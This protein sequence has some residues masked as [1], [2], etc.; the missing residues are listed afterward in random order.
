MKARQQ[1]LGTYSVKIAIALLILF[2]G[3]FL[4]LR[5]DVSRNR[6]YSLTPQTRQSL[7]S[8]QDRVVVK[9]FASQDLSPQLSN[10]NRSLRDMLTEFARLSRGKLQFE[11]VRAKSNEDLIEQAKQYS[12]Q[13]YTVVT[14]ENDQQV[15]KLVVLG[16]SF[17]SGGKTSATYLR[18]GMETMLEYQILKHLNQ[19]NTA[20]LPALSVFA[21]SLGLMFQYGN[22]PDE[23]A[24]FFLELMQNYNIVRTDL[25]KPPEFTP[26]MLC[27]G[28]IDSLKTEQLYNLDQYLMRGGMVVMCQDR[29]AVFNTPQGTGVIEIKSALYPL[30]EHYGIH[31]KPNIVLDRECEIRQGS[32]LGS[33]VPYPFFPLIRPNPRYPYTMGFESIYLYFASEVTAMAGSKLKY[34]PVLQTSARSNALDGPRYD[35]ELAINQGLDP[36]FLNLPPKTVAAEFSGKITSYYNA[37]PGDSNYRASNDKARFIVFGD[38]E[39]PIDFGAGTFIVLNAVDQLLGR[40]GMQRLRSPREN[41]SFLGVDVLIQKRKLAPSDPERE[42]SHLALAFKLTAIL[43]PSLL[44]ALAGII[45]LVRKNARE[46]S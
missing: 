29:V 24:T 5:L 3:G 12:I 13:P 25:L 31:I 27:L 1:I 32:G 42:T 45:S 30:L 4:Y 38:S 34:E 20:N 23:T 36:G 2:V 33:Q 39:L 43:L 26:V 40:A 28:V 17:E 6:A 41:N 19:L 11:Y 46:R 7:R 22:N 14:M 37:A 18:P 10:L 44:L 9:V 16:L 15:S 21:D 35:L 8:L